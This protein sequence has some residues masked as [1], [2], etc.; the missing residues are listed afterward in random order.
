M[1]IEFTR[2]V[3]PDTPCSEC[4]AASF[5]IDSNYLRKYF[6]SE[7]IICSK[8]KAKL[9][10]WSLLLRHLEWNF[11]FYL[12][13]LVGALDTLIMLKMKPNEV[14]V[15][16]MS[17][18]GIPKEA[19]ILHIG[20][21][22]N[23]N[24]LFPLEIHGN[25]PIRHFT[26]HKISL[27]G[28]PFGEPATETPVAVSITWI[29]TFFTEDSWQNLIQ[30][31]EAYS[32]GKFNSAIIPANVAVESKLNQ[33]LRLHLNKVASVDRVAEFLDTRATYSY[34]LNILL[35]L[36]T[37]H[38]GYPKMPNHIRG[39][40]N[41]L[42]DLRNDIAHKGKLERQ[43]DKR[44]SAELLCAAVFGLGYINLLEDS[45]RRAG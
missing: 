9:D 35:P 43:L 8:C 20:Y 25:T 17:E 14:T 32:I 1:N 45:M 15:L 34:Q 10:W 5:P 37:T 40:L 44:Q 16:D 22:P 12:Y 19:K 4:K 41:T 26:P 36:I 33:V 31:F 6:F 42:R 3:I 18:V 27:F 2:T 23:G 24:G 11:P 38:L 39:F 30:A 28:R 7:D 13:G 29:Q 21:T